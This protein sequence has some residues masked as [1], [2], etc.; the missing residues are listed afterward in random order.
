MMHKCFNVAVL[1]MLTASFKQLYDHDL[2][3]TVDTFSSYITLAYFR[4]YK[5]MY[6]NCNFLKI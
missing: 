5:L 4:Y 6:S 3:N 2:S 1:V